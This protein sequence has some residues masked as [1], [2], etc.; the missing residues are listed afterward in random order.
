MTSDYGPERTRSS[1]REK[2]F[3]LLNSYFRISETWAHFLDL[4]SQIQSRTLGHLAFLNFDIQMGNWG[5]LKMVWLSENSVMNNCKSLRTGIG[6][7][8]VH[9]MNSSY[10]LAFF[11]FSCM[12][13]H[14]FIE[15]LECAFSPAGPGSSSSTL[16]R[17]GPAPVPPCTLDFPLPTEPAQKWAHP[18]PF[19]TSYGTPSFSNVSCDSL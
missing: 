11:F 17:T 4:L 8:Q 19:R 16:L 12:E 7:V 15:H 3:Q 6:M 10:P 18:L 13:D 2:M 14:V 9:S 5:S 1:V